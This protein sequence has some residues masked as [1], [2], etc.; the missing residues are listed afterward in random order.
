MG[1]EWPLCLHHHRFEFFVCFALWVIFNLLQGRQTCYLSGDP[2]FLHGLSVELAR[3]ELAH[4][5]HPI[6]A[7]PDNTRNPSNVMTEHTR[8][9]SIFLDLKAAL[10]FLPLNRLN[11]SIQTLDFL[12]LIFVCP[13]LDHDVCRFAH[14][15]LFRYVLGFTLG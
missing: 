13:C 15:P 8:V 1:E 6:R 4:L 5:V 2:A 11:Q 10:S 7:L 9:I 12:S 14:Y 3:V